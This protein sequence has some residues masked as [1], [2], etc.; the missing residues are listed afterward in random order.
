MERNRNKA[1]ANQT[2][3]VSQAQVNQTSQISGQKSSMSD[4]NNLR[5]NPWIVSTFVLGV[6]VIVLIASFGFGGV[7]GEIVSEQVAADNL[8]N[9]IKS[10]NKEDVD[11]KVNS[12]SQDGQ[13]YK[14]VL[15]YQ[16]QDVPIYVSLDGKYL[17]SDIIP[18]DSGLVLNSGEDIPSDVEVE[19]GDSPVKGEAD[20]PV[21]IIEFLDYQCPFC[22]RF[23]KQTLPLIEEQYIKTG[24]VRL[25]Y[26]DFPLISIHP[27]AEKA[28]E[29]AR[30][31]REQKGDEGYF[32]M[33]DKLFENQQELSV[34]NYKKWARDLG[35]VGTKFDECLDK[36]KYSDA[37]EEELAYGE[38]LG[39]TGTPAFFINGRMI[40]GAQP[41]DVFKQAIDS[42][43]EG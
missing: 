4:L 13:L 23:F 7:T 3:S 25:V 39:V 21:T 28:A 33:H 42:A 36:G 10:Q 32:K 40:S 15:D 20:A 43:L 14:I 22:E 16:G 31:A 41:F 1:E 11:L 37:V 27:E 26:K 8:I 24:K 34:E 2:S 38:Q 29:A 30:C 17:V 19:A 6:V 35:V 9:F 12:V 18:L 5:E